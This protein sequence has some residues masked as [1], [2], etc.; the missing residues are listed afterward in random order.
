MNAQQTTMASSEARRITPGSLEDRY[1]GVLLGGCVGDVL[2]S[3]NENLSFDQIRKEKRIVKDFVHNR[4]TDDTEMTLVLA[5][6]LKQHHGTTHSPVQEVHAMYRD[7]M[8]TSKRGYSKRTRQLLTNWHDC[9]PGGNADTN[10]AVMRIAPLAFVNHRDDRDL[11]NHIKMV[12]YCT[13]GES[14]DA[15]D[16]AFL[17][18]KLLKALL[19]GRCTTAEQLYAYILTVGRRIQNT[20][21]FP[22]LHLLHPDNRKNLFKNGMAT[23]DDN[24]TKNIFGFDFMQI[25]AIHAYVCVLACFLYNFNQPVDAL[26]MAS[27]LGGDTDTIAKM[28]GDLAGARFGTDWIPEP[29]SQPE[30]AAELRQLGSDLYHKLN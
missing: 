3:Y 17:H 26:I 22:L 19:S 27:N 1:I 10:G 30:G 7:I 2:G 9:M 25:K 28:I 11:Y 6:Y 23:L 14:K 29:W 5:R 16:T 8:K 21:L 13:H 12:I 24:V 18:V 4:Y 20:T 15:L